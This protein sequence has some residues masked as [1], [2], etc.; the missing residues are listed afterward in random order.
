MADSIITN[1]CCV[2]H[3]EKPI[4]QFTA[5]NRRENG[6]SSLCRQCDKA[7]R[8]AWRIANKEFLSRY[9]AAYRNINRDAIT[10]KRQIRRSD[11][12]FKR[13]RLIWQ[14]EYYQ[15][16]KERNRD[17]Q[18]ANAAVRHAVSDGKLQRPDALRC[19]VC[20]GPANNYHHHL[21]YSPDHQLDVIPV[22]WECHFVLDKKTKY[23]I[24]NALPLIVASLP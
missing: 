12:G 17:K 9:Y 24:G 10:R 6:K 14:R 2:C 20:S 7:R 13:R 4:E 11:E 15:R 16:T 1:Q 5:D 23:C 22:C 19:S 8:K 3:V 18:H 21:G